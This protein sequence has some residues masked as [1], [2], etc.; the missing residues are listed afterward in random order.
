[1][2]VTTVF[3]NS[4]TSFAIGSIRAIFK[5]IIYFIYALVLII[6]LTFF[7]SKLNISS[8]I[9]GFAS[10]IKV[11]ES[12]KISMSDIKNIYP[13]FND[14]S[15]F[16]KEKIKEEVAQVINDNSNENDVLD[17]FKFED[18]VAAFS[19]KSKID[20]SK[21]VSGDKEVI[22]IG[23]MKIYNYSSLRDI[24]YQKICDKVITLTKS[25]DKILLYNTHTSEAYTNSEKYT[26]GYDGTFRSRSA[27]VNMLSVAAK[28]QKNLNEKNINVI[29]D[30]TPHDYGTYT[31]AYA[32]SK[33]TVKEAIV[34]NGGFGIAIDVHRDAGSDTSFAPK[35]KIN[36]LD[37]AQC[38]FV[39]GV[40][41]N[42]NRNQYYED[43]LALAIQLQLLANK[44][45]PGL[46][47][48]MYIRDSVY[49]QD[50][51]KYSLLM[52]FGATGNTL[53][54][55]YRTTRCISNLLNIVYKK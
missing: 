44:I 24:D 33:T 22:T 53:D 48:T 5:N 26:F 51:N 31:S 21:V 7:I 6:S 38:M 30:T 32:R 43:N 28:L 47:R 55:V 49:N 37:V 13:I 23:D 20:I 11:T 40:G 14:T 4:N 1:M 45:Y 52:E 41:T 9:I 19:S 10:N 29:H 46:F 8:N 15:Y 25:S 2:K 3:L 16:I 42:K 18:A 36:G 17:N 27:S 34:N 54:E 35:T 12:Y 50:L 39:M